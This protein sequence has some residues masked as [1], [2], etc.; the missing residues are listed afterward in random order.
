MPPKNNIDTIRLSERVRIKEEI[1]QQTKYNDV[2]QN[3]LTTFRG[4]NN[5]DNYTLK[6]VEKLSKAIEERT[7]KIN[8]LND[9]LLQLEN[10]NLDNEILE[11]IKKNT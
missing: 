3:S 11:K 8:E 1:R 9:R 5:N 10:G 4:I 2:D 6:Q 7:N